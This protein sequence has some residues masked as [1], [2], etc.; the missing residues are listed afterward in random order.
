MRNEGPSEFPPLLDRKLACAGQKFAPIRYFLEQS[1]DWTSRRLF[2]WC[3]ST[4]LS[5]DL[6]PKIAEVLKTAPSQDSKWQTRALSPLLFRHFW[7]TFARESG[8]VQE[9]RA[10]AVQWVH[11]ISKTTFLSASPTFCGDSARSPETNVAIA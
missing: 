2:S 6:E 8:T 1:H 10:S 11:E 7:A 5:S 4:L 3:A 9:P